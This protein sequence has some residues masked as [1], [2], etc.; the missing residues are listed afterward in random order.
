MAKVVET[1]ER[2]G[3]RVN[4]YDNGM[5]K[6]ADNGH[7]I[8]GPNG[9][10]ITAENATVF[11]RQRMEKKRQRAVAGANA[12]L[13]RM[14]DKE[15]GEPAWENPQDMDFIEALAEAQTVEA[16]NGGAYASKAAEFVVRV[17]GYDERT[18]GADG[19]KPMIGAADVLSA[20][21]ELVRLLR[22]A[23]QPRAD[24]IE[25]KVTEAEIGTDTL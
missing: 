6:N 11:V 4:V 19:E 14:I 17:T 20:T 7:F 15:T 5:E 13:R 16:L 8:K 23:V 10:M 21:A 3:I 22:E 18:Q 12:A 1:I 2:D 25:G 9:S 24:V